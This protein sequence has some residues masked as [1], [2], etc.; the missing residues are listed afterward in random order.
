MHYFAVL[1]VDKKAPAPDN[2]MGFVIDSVKD[3]L[4]AL[5]RYYPSNKMAPAAEIIRS[6]LLCLE[7]KDKQILFMCYPFSTEKKGAR[8]GAY[9]SMY[10]DLCRK[11]RLLKM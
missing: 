3:T 9:A 5:F 8:G 4:S 1:S 11:T 10:A 7:E 2:L 6:R